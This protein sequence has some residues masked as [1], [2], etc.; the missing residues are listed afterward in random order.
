M[1][2]KQPESDRE[3]LLEF[4]CEFP[5]KVMGKDNEAFRNAAAAIIEKHAGELAD[6]AMRSS[7]S[8][9]AKFISLTVTIRAESQNQ[10][11]D[12]YRELSAHDDVLVVL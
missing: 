7:R 4:P 1:N 10:L 11:D 3:S 6:G 2:D 5:I 12:I 9:T 8:R